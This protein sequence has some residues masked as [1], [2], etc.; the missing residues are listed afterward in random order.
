MNPTNK[1]QAK[2]QLEFMKAMVAEKKMKKV[3]KI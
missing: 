3:I 2:A 1:D